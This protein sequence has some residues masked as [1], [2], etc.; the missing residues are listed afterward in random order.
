[1]IIMWLSFGKIKQKQRH[2][3]DDLGQNKRHIQH[4]HLGFLNAEILVRTLVHIHQPIPKIHNHHVSQFYALMVK[5]IP[6]HSTCVCTQFQGMT[7]ISIYVD[8]ILEVVPPP[9]ELQ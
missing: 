5:M 7:V 1:M 3:A 4:G 6:N 8:L 9:D 2:T